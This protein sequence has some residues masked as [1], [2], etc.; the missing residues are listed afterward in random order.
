MFKG[1]FLK[2]NQKLLSD[3]KIT[4]AS[5]VMLMGKPEDKTVDIEKITKDQK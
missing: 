1:K 3:Y 5:K 4:A 2:D